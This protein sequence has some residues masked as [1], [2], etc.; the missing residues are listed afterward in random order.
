MTLAECGVAFL[1]AG[2]LLLAP[3]SPW[4]DSTAGHRG[5]FIRAALI[6]E[7][8]VAD[9]L[10]PVEVAYDS[11]ARALLGGMAQAQAELVRA[12]DANMGVMMAI[13]ALP[14]DR[15][16]TKRLHDLMTQPG[17]HDPYVDAHTGSGQ[18]VPASEMD[19][20]YDALVA[21]MAHRA[22]EMLDE[23]STSATKEA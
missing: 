1:V 14:S 23:H 20:A 3:Q 7:T 13:L 10:L 16:S 9:L 19:R 4:P 8:T 21:A 5:W 17:A 22:A 18:K 15:L 2:G 12:I 6:F 11:K